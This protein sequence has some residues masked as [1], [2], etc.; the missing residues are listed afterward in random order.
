[1]DRL[2]LI[3]FRK[4]G[5][6]SFEGGR[7]VPRMV[8][9]PRQRNALYAFVS[10]NKA[11]Y[12]GKTTSTLTVR[13]RGYAS[14]GPTQ[15]TNIRCRANILAELNGGRLVEIWALPDEGLL[16]LGGFRLNLPAAL[17]DDIIATLKPRWNGGKKDMLVAK[18]GGGGTEEVVE[19]VDR[20]G[21]GQRT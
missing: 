13:L 20:P 18:P 2:R 14:P 1:M 8:D 3:G 12:V 7:P 9:V 6:W 15:G 16:Q 5:Q 4:I 11:L 21:E 10:D 17:E 19:M